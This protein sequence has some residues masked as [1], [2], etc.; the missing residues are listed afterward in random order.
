[1]R[2][3]DRKH[4]TMP[5]PFT[6]IVAIEPRSKA[7]SD[8]L[9]DALARLAADDPA[10][11]FERDAESG[12]MCLAGRDEDHLGGKL[13]ALI[14]D[15]GLGINAGAPQ[16]A[17]RE[18]ITRCVDVEH[19]YTRVLGPK[20]DFARVKIRFEPGERGSGFVFESS[21]VGGAVP[22][23]FIPGVEKGIV[24]AKDNGLLAGFPVIDFKATLYGGGYHDV[25]SS[26]LAFEIASRAAFRELREKGAPKLLEPI[27]KVEVLTPDE[28]MGDVIGDLN[29][30]RGQIQGAE[31]R[32][33]AQV[34]TAFV[35]LSNLFGYIN[36]LHS[37]S[38]GRVSFTMQYD[39][40]DDVPLPPHDPGPENFPPAIGMRA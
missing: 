37:F 39:H 32:G 27:M 2:F 29:S 11:T 31:S 30:R 6:T 38:Q 14:H 9:R 20:A 35:P 16:V 4:L 13:D 36:T 12:Q 17:Y 26:V 3:K 18:A 1:V 10:F 34:V 8:R 19:T 33:N 25:D 22:K 21:I 40:Y 24:S 7:D 28:Y 15:F 23:E 5:P